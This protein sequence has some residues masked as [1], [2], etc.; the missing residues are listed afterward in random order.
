MAVLPPSPQA[1]S[2]GKYG[3]IPLNL[4]TG[5]PGYSISIF[6]KQVN[7]GIDLDLSI[8]Y[9]TNGIKV[10]ELGGV[11]GL[12]WA[13]FAGGVITRTVNDNPDELSQDIAAPLTNSTPAQRSVVWYEDNPLK[14][15]IHYA[16]SPSYDL[17]PDLF[18]FNFFGNSGQFFID[19][20]KVFFIDHMDLKFETNWGTVNSPWN[21]KV[22]D[23]GGN[24]F[25]FGG[26]A[27]SEKSNIQNTVESLS[28]F[29]GNWTPAANEVTA[30]YLTKVVTPNA[31][32][33]VFEYVSNGYTTQSVRS[34]TLS[35]QSLYNF[36]GIDPSQPCGNPDPA[37]V[38]RTTRTLNGYDLKKIKVNKSIQVNFTHISNPDLAGT[39]LVSNITIKDL[40]TNQNIKQAKFIY[41]FSNSN[42]PL[43]SKLV[44]CDALG[45]Q[46]DSFKFAYNG[47][48]PSR[49]S[50]AKD[51]YGY[52]NGSTQDREV[53]CNTAR[54]G[55]LTK[56]TYPTGGS[57]EIGYD[58]A[59][60][61]TTEQVR[62]RR[63]AGSLLGTGLDD[64]A[65]K[66]Y[67]FDWVVPQPYPSSS[68]I[69]LNVALDVTWLAACCPTPIYNKAVVT[70]YNKR[71]HQN[72]EVIKPFGTGY[73]Y[74]EPGHFDTASILGFV[75]GDTLT[76]KLTSYGEW[77][78]ARA[79]FYYYTNEDVTVTHYY[80]ASRVSNVN[81]YD[82]VSNTTQTKKYVYEFKDQPGVSSGV[83]LSPV[84]NNESFYMRHICPVTN[85]TSIYGYNFKTCLYNMV[86]DY[87]QFDLFSYAPSSYLYRS[88]LELNGVNGEN[89]MTEH[90]FD[91]RMPERAYVM[92][93]NN[94]DVPSTYN[95][96]FAAPFSLM[97]GRIATE[98]QTNQYARSAGG[99][100]PVKMNRN[101]F[102]QRKVFKE[103]IGYAVN[104]VDDGDDGTLGQLND[105]KGDVK[106]FTYRSSWNTLDSTVVTNYLDDGNPLVTRTEYQYGNE[107]HGL[108]TVIRSNRGDGTESWQLNNYPLDYLG[109]N[110]YVAAMQAKH[111]NN[112]PIEQLSIINKNGNLLVSDGALNQYLQ[113]KPS[114]LEKQYELNYQSPVNSAL[115]KISNRATGSDLFS[116]I[117][118]TLQ[119]SS[120]YTS[121]DENVSFDENGKPKETVDDKGHRFAYIWAYGGEYLTAKVDNA[122]A[123][124]IAYTSFEDDGQHGN[125][126]YTAAIGSGIS[127]DPYTPTGKYVY[128]IPGY[129]PITCNGLDPSK[130]YV[131]SFYYRGSIY[132]IIPNQISSMSNGW[133]NNYTYYEAIISGTTTASISFWST[134]QI[135][136]LRL[137]P[138]E[139]SMSTTC[140]DP[141]KGVVTE[142][143]ERSN[144][145]RYV[146]DDKGRLVMIKDRTDGIINKF[147]YKLQQ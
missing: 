66:E 2:M 43:L 108:P 50:N 26:S 124:D 134:V 96:W 70:G 54:Y 6:N 101:W 93:V 74:V 32:T 56:I 125:W 63:D 47:F 103:K 102:S 116:Y 141:S 98:T 52:Y 21:F 137:Y 44:Q 24:I 68:S 138:V 113:N 9:N 122:K 10:E 57:D 65:A 20:G 16:G 80:G 49:A 40:F 35:S 36:G 132:P 37:L 97:Y 39:Q 22:T 17:Q 92:Y 85:G 123:S 69:Y 23:A 121:Y 99:Y 3:G 67:S 7:N 146:Y 12:G 55:M 83:A 95:D 79:T 84:Y 127:A 30:W 118:T 105:I 19:S 25:F 94:V 53:N 51:F 46:C 120:D 11:T 41:D 38:M 27:A 112:L 91:I 15:A 133:V 140:Y 81:T 34:R 130:K 62:V 107:D 129:T 82:P 5:A 143:D 136:E 1:S 64:H 75:P 60:S 48:L 147:T 73:F 8:N 90:T 18:S 100:T 135:D 76:L 110:D 145:K 142:C 58:C 104:K 31:D 4:S 144:V 115:F 109:N 114:I 45:N 42:R 29:P 77:V 139:A 87:S 61:T 13:L 78:E 111:I 119:K 59:S 88:V 28:G 126:N 72:L 14:R 106:Q 89:G 86:S 128:D 131:L 117:K 71:T 33:I